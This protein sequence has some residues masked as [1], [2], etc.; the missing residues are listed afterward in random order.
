MNVL[1]IKN[2]SFNYPKLSILNDISLILKEKSITAVLAPNGTGKTTLFYNILGILKPT[3]G[4]IYTQECDILALKPE[5]RAK[6]ICYVPQEWQSPFN[7]NVVDVVMMGSTRKMRIFGTP[8]YQDEKKALELMEEM[9][10]IHL[11]FQGINE[12]SGGQRQMVLLAR[13][14]LQDAPILLLD[15]PT[16]H[17]DIKNQALLFRELK[18]QVDKKNLSVLINIHDPNLV[19]IYA[20]E[21]YMLKDG[22]N[23]RNGQVNEVMNAKNLSELYGLE[24]KTGMIDSRSFVYVY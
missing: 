4:Q 19:N 16:S 23:F 22:K 11:K 10:I 14:L 15:E 12:I 17:L 20:D 8:Q 18:K 9:G 7:Y 6:Y 1:T 21:V 24:V 13:A 2:L 5:L 3:K